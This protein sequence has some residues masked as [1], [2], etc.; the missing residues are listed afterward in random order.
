M[1]KLVKIMIILVVVILVAVLGV[2]AWFV[3]LSQEDETQSQDETPVSCLEFGCDENAIYV[4]SIN[5]D[6]Y[7][8]CGCHY[9]E[10]ILPENIICF[11]SDEDAL[12][13]NRIK[14]EC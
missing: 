13:N 14:S 4:G 7:Y 10:Q 6:K 2:V 12:A 1:E 5:S 11:A 9:A 3:Y 8:E